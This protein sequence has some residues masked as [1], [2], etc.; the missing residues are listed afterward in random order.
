MS[1]M[2][3]RDI[4]LQAARS[5]RRAPCRALKPVARGPG[6]VAGRV[7]DGRMILQLSLDHAPVALLLMSAAAIAVLGLAWLARVLSRPGRRAR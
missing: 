6:P 5:D 2:R 7:Y 3:I 1:G 4:A